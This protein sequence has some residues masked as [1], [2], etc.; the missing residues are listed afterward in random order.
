MS[1]TTKI[2]EV[3][4]DANKENRK[5]EALVRDFEV[6]RNES[7][8][9]SSSINDLTNRINMI[10]DILKTKCN[11]EDLQGINLRIHTELE[12]LKKKMNIDT[13]IIRLTEE[14]KKKFID[15]DEYEK[16]MNNIQICLE[17]YVY[18]NDNDTTNNIVMNDALNEKVGELELKIKNIESKFKPQVP[19]STPR[20]PLKVNIRQNK[21]V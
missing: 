21:T 4:A 11:N 7:I 6:L 2:F 8:K 19:T 15:V 9:V 13:E 12:E 5:I 3:L 1:R 20:Q 17:K 16:D 10:T 14:L 18:N